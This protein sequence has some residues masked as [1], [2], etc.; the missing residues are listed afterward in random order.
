M[1]QEI[2]PH[3]YHN[4]YRPAEPKATDPAILWRDGKIAMQLCEGGVCLPQVAQVESSAWQYLFCIDETDYFLC[5]EDVLC[6]EGFEW[7]PSRGVDDS[8]P[9]HASFALAVAASLA[10]WYSGRRFCGACGERMQ[11][12]DKERAMVCPACGK[13]VY[14]TISP[15]VIVGVADGEKLLLTRYAGRPFNRYALVAGFNEIGEGIEATVKRE[16]KEET[17]LDVGDLRF[18]ASQ[19]WCFSDSLLMGF[20]CRLTG[21]NRIV[22]QEDELA[23]ARWFTREELPE[24]HSRLSLTGNMIEFFRENGPAAIWGE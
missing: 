2:A 21:E 1:L 18:F 3:I 11:H 15:A 16:V 24:N 23:E 22:L 7:L 5:M 13:I 10:R 9:Q 6:P 19:P 20:Y 14:P 8:I 12:S 4:E 17:G